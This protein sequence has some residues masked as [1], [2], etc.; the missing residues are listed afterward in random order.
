MFPVG[1]ATDQSSVVFIDAVIP[2]MHPETARFHPTFV[3]C[4]ISD[5]TVAESTSRRVAT[6]TKARR[7]GRKSFAKCPDLQSE[8]M[9]RRDKRP[10][11]RRYSSMGGP[12]MPDPNGSTTVD[13]SSLKN[14]VLLVLGSE[15]Q[16]IP[17]F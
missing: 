17:A 9:G 7:H 14:S 4:E 10:L 8:R 1:Y 13:S 16:G 12:T 15:F 3:P 6:C 5:Q 11:R 2:L